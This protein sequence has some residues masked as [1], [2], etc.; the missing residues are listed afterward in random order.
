MV[1]DTLVGV[2]QH[3]D[4]LFW[5]YW[6]LGRAVVGIFELGVGI[7]KPEF[8][9]GTGFNVFRFRI[10]KFTYNAGPISIV[11]VKNSSCNS[12]SFFFIDIV[13]LVLF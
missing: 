12:L 7:S 4:H 2:L 9:F 5:L 13:I 10:R 11:V 1:V 6:V 8:P 3:A